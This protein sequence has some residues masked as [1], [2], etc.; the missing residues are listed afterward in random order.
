MF[1]G[2]P[3]IKMCYFRFSGTV[4]DLDRIDLAHFI[5]I[6]LNMFIRGHQHGC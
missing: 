4:I 3:G 1:I 2:F 5:Q 6:R